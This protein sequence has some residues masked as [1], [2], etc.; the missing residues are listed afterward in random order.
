MQELEFR[1]ALRDEMSLVTRPRPMNET[2]LLDAARHA[3]QRRRGAW[4][5]A[6][7]VVAVAALAVGTVF[8]ATGDSRPGPGAGVT[9]TTQP[10]DDGVPTFYP[11]ATS[12]PRYEQSATLLN[13]MLD[14]VPPGFDT[15]TD[16]TAPGGNNM[17]EHLASTRGVPGEQWWE[18]VAAVPIAREGR[19]GR[20]LA[21]VSTPGNDLPP[22]Q[23]CELTIAETGSTA[24][25]EILV[26]DIRIGVV[27]P[28]P[29]EH[30]AGSQVAVYRHQDGTVVFIE[31]DYG[32]F[33]ISDPDY[34]PLTEMPLT[35]QQLAKLAT[36]SR[37]HLT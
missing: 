26:G 35:P 28:R 32:V 21:A 15:P 29:N 6:G 1:Q 37:L 24:C 14:A 31:Q 13:L 27:T 7:S 19:F 10:D 20:L 17:R 22:V 16:V 18:Y 9:S 36:D 33:L 12:G 34:P 11:Y 8:T 3:L 2:A 25:Q 5:S 23:G 4:A 30:G